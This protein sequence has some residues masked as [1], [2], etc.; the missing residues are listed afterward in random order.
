M[1][2]TLDD[3]KA[4]SSSSGAGGSSGG[5]G[6]IGVDIDEIDR[7]LPEQLATQTDVVMFNKS[8]ETTNPGEPTNLTVSTSSDNECAVISFTAPTH[9]GTYD[10]L[11]YAITVELNKNDGAGFVDV[12]NIFAE[13]YNDGQYKT[14]YDVLSAVLTT[15]TTFSIPY[16]FIGTITES[17]EMRFKVCTVN[18]RDYD[19]LITVG[20][21]GDPKI[22]KSNQVSVNHN[23]GDLINS[24]ADATGTIEPHTGSDTD[25][26]N[27]VYGSRGDYAI[28]G[29]TSNISKVKYLLATLESREIELGEDAEFKNVLSSKLGT[30]YNDL[31]G[32]FISASASTGISEIIRKEFISDSDKAS[33]IRLVIIQ[34]LNEITYGVCLGIVC[35]PS[36]VDSYETIDLPEGKLIDIRFLVHQ[37][38][39]AAGEADYLENYDFDKDGEVTTTDLA[40]C[41]K[42]LLGVEPCPGG[43]LI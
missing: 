40:K 21:L 1:G 29:N 5:G 30:L 38:K 13:N 36:Y 11:G 33:T 35:T 43:Y 18:A 16:T 10:R 9:E 4:G 12:T 24:I 41:R 7:I 17:T 34:C 37:K 8:I 25:L 42:I 26:N 31:G 27:K 28:I 20:T 19:A 15:D 39:I 32:C 2:N 22:L 6:F 23:V 14:N 3:I